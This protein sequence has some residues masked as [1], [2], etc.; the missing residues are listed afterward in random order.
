MDFSNYP[1]DHK[2]FTLKN[3]AKL[4]F[5]KDELGGKLS[6]SEFVGLRAKCYSMKLENENYETTE[7]KYARFRPCCD[8]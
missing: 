7:K 1:P 8:R 3:K 6:V 4:G 5:F 2:N